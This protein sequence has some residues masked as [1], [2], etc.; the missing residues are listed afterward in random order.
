MYCLCFCVQPL[1]V[2]GLLIQNFDKLSLKNCPFTKSITVF[3]SKICSYIIKSVR[4][5][6][7]RNLQKATE[8]VSAEVFRPK[9]YPTKFCSKFILLIIHM[10]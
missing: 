1:R 6:F 7:R 8:N 9:F 3:Q 10:C 5:I 4:K 2:L